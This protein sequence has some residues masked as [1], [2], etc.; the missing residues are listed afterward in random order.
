M[1]LPDFL[2]HTLVGMHAP[3]HGTLATAVTAPERCL[4]PFETHTWRLE[5]ES[6]PAMR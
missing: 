4:G 1:L 5:A 6:L 3:V 2:L